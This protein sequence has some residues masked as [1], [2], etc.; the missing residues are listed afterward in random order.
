[1]NR[2]KTSSAPRARFVLAAFVLLWG[3]SACTTTS[4]QVGHASV[5]AGQPDPCK[6]PASIEA[7]C[8]DRKCSTYEESAAY[9]R[10][11]AQGNGM[12]RYELG[13]CGSYRYLQMQ[14]GMGLG[15]DY[16]DATGK[17]VATTAVADAP[18]C[19]GEFSSSVGVIPTCEK[20]ATEHGEAHFE[21]AP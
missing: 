8:A 15:T 11:E 21:S 19:T 10:H 13:T 18:R 7:Y 16:F 14:E 12:F 6:E 17:L 9:A 1:M 3:A 20:K 4:P 5:T 2:T